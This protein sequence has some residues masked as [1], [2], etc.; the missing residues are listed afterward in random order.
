M[1]KHRIIPIVLIDG[2][3]VLKTINFD[4]RRNLGSPITVMQTYETRNVD[5]MIILDIDATK[6]KRSID[7]FTIKEITQECFMPLTIGGGL[8]H[9]KDIEGILNVGADKVS[10]N[11]SAILDKNFLSQAVKNFGSQCI[12]VSIDVIMHDGKLKLFSDG[13]VNERVDVFDHMKSVEES[14]AGE[15]LVTDV[16]REGTMKGANINLAS[17]IFSKSSV[18]LIFAGGTSSPV[19]AANLVKNTG[20]SAVGVSSIFHFTDFTPEDCRIALRSADLPARQDR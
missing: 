10:L 17:L 2:F 12:V 3:S 18:P 11:S 19:D 8:R 16:S 6:Q 14:G 4:T 20:M 9:C 15:L 1:L 13:E 5:E 7:K